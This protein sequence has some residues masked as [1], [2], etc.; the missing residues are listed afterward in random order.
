[1]QHEL[2]RS[3]AEWDL[4]LGNSLPNLDV[5]SLIASFN[6]HVDM[7]LS[8]SLKISKSTTCRGKKIQAPWYPKIFRLTF[9]ENL[10]YRNFNK[11]DIPLSEK[12]VLCSVWKQ[13]RNRLRNA[14]RSQER[15]TLKAR[16]QKLESLD[17]L[18]LENTGR[19][20][21]ILIRQMLNLLRLFLWWL[22]IVRIKLSRV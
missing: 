10:S 5:N 1:M 21:L 3:L 18:I 19:D 7:A 9:E 22:K 4:S 12:M 6:S 13:C 2:A 16:I 15:L 20:L 14:Y 8:N 17:L 11:D